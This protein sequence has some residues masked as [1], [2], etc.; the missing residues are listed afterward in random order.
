[1]AHR[2]LLLSTLLISTC[3][4]AQ[5]VDWLRS[6][7]VHWNMNPDAPRHLVSAAPDGAVDLARQDSLGGA[8]SSYRIER[9]DE[10]GTVL[11]SLPVGT[12]V[13][14]QSLFTDASGQV[15]AGGLFSGDLV[16][17]E[18]TLHAVGEHAFLLAIS[19]SGEPLWSRDLLPEFPFAQQVPCIRFDANGHG[20]FCVT[21]FNNATLVRFDELGAD[22]ETRAINGVR[23]IGGFDF[24]PFD[25]VFVSG[26]ASS[27]SP[28][29]CGGLDTTIIESYAMFVLR[30]DATG[31]ASW[32]RF[33]HDETF[34]RPCVVADDAGNAFV[35]GHLLVGTSFG[36][37]SFHG[38]NWVYDTFLLK[39]DAMGNFVWGLESAPAGGP[40]TGD[41]DRSADQCIAKGQN[42]RVYLLG[43]VRGQVQWGNGIS[44]DGITLGG[45]AQSVICFNAEGTAQ[46]QTTGEVNGFFSGSQNIC[47][48]ANS[49]IH[50]ATQASGAFTFG[51]I[52]V[53]AGGQQAVVARITDLLTT[54]VQEQAVAMDV[55]A[56]PSPFIDA[57]YLASP[58]QAALGPVRAV[59][60]SGRVV[61]DG[62]YNGSLGV[63]WSPGVYAISVIVNHVTHTLRVVKE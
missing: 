28:F 50:C 10:S 9:Y 41:F 8:A 58:Q 16:V 23:T 19:N 57:L 2:Y 14:V 44:S 11:W 40:I 4:S 47:A 42:G 36:A 18:D 12:N 6:A 20:W 5:Q 53:D 43:A 35:A 63:G 26:S 51:G 30:M 29:S 45:M 21:D 52:T 34:Q 56:Y 60:M 39:V 27:T 7:P 31:V 46:W 48:D 33:A 62:V 25:N 38:P 37:I 22:V 13:Q 15:Y 3:S 54:S 59:D 17:Q 61:F 32:V 55:L 1:M 49:V 24:D